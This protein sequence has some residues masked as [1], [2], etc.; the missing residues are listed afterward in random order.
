MLTYS[1][2]RDNTLDS[3]IWPKKPNRAFRVLGPIGGPDRA[4]VSIDRAGVRARPRPV[5]VAVRPV[6]VPRFPFSGG[7]TARPTLSLR[8][9]F[10][11]RIAYL[12][13]GLLA[14]MA[15]H[16]PAPLHT[17]LATYA[18]TEHDAPISI[19][20]VLRIARDHTMTKRL[21]QRETQTLGVIASPL[22]RDS[23]G[24][25]A[26]HGEQGRN[27]RVRERRAGRARCAKRTKPDPIASPLQTF[28]PYMHRTLPLG[29]CLANRKHRAPYTFH[30]TIEGSPSNQTQ[31]TTQESKDMENTEQ[32]LQTHGYKLAERLAQEYANGV[33][34][35]EL[36]GDCGLTTDEVYALIQ[37]GK[38]EA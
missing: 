32:L 34:L 3:P 36:A 27:A 2:R 37:A 19:C 9:S 1:R 6:S 11:W 14:R 12:D 15:Q 23:H 5:P 31:R 33:T 10:V 4:G 28:R 26:T 24:A 21:L 13:G 16:T 25:S 38:E 20:R 8:L 7:L 17:T 18:L 22:E 35:D 30:S 29:V